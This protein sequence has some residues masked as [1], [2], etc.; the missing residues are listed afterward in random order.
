MKFPGQVPDV[1]LSPQELNSFDNPVSFGTLLVYDDLAQQVTITDIGSSE[2]PPSF[3]NNQKEK[4]YMYFSFFFKYIYIRVY[5]YDKS[6]QP[7]WDLQM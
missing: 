1:V 4:V 5:I 7:V 6:D 3:S 2:S